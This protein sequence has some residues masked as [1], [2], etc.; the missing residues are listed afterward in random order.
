MMRTLPALLLSGC[1][2]TVALNAPQGER[3]AVT[4][5]GFPHAVLDRVVKKVVN[6]RGRVDYKT[7]AADRTE[8]VRYLA[9][10][11][12]VSPH[13]H[14]E[15]FPSE[16]ERLAYW[17]NA[18]NAYVLY[19]VTERPT[20]RS[21][22]DDATT[23]FYFTRYRFGAEELSLYDVENEVVRKEFAEP[24][25][26]FAL[27]CASNGCP[28]LPPEAFVPDRLEDQLAREAREFCAH[29]DKVRVDGDEVE[30]SQIFEWYSADFAAAGGPIELCRR[31]GRRDLPPADRADLSFITYDWTINAQTGR[32]LFE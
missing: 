7:L 23:F 32:A 26:H 29:P 14:P 30:M 11:A 13:T 25:I 17:I 9:V 6:D 2:T 20:M 3:L 8:L 5:G 28:E 21:V 27:N 12:E 24:R 19:A 31:W 1:F 18:Y 15:L 4:P 22:D 16:Q 10:V